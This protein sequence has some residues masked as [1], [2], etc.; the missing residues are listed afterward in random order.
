[1]LSGYEHHAVQYQVPEAAAW[2]QHMTGGTETPSLL[3][4]TPPQPPRAGPSSLPPNH[5]E[6]SALHS[7]PPTTTTLPSHFP[8]SAHR[9][10]PPFLPSHPPTPIVLS[11]CS[12]LRPQPLTFPPRPPTPIHPSPSLTVLHHSSTNTPSFRDPSVCPSVSSMPAFLN[13]YRLSLM[14]T[15]VPALPSPS[16]T[17]L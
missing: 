6:L 4:G 15:F 3:P 11:S 8:L 7:N 1:M 13:N 14:P 17:S 9:P 12:P 10:H 5:P 2:W 16:I